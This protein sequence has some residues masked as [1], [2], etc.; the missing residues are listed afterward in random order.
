MGAGNLRSKVGEDRSKVGDEAA[1][2]RTAS[3][4]TSSLRPQTRKMHKVGEEGAAER[5]TTRRIVAADKE[6][7]ASRYAVCVLYWY[8]SANTDAEGGA[9]QCARRCQRRAGESLCISFLF[10]TFFLSF[11][12]LTHEIEPYF[13]ASDLHV[14]LLQ[15]PPA[16]K[17]SLRPHT[18]VA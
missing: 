3:S 7:A 16:V 18:L 8:K 13:I 2:E 10:F 17:S 9:K 5:T 11:L 1:A 4:Y 12:F 15:M 6:R 14:K